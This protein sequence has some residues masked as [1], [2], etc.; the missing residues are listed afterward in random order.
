MSDQRAASR[1][2][3]IALALVLAGCGSAPSAS[4]VG[5]LTASPTSSDAVPSA[6]ASPTAAPTQIPS[7]AHATGPTDVA[8]RFEDRSGSSEFGGVFAPGPIFTLYG[9]GTVIFRNDLAM[10]PPAEGSIIRARPFLI[11]HLDEDQVQSVLRFA[12][13]EG[14]L[15]SVRQA[16]D[17]GCAVYGG[18]LTGDPWALQ[19]TV[20][21]GGLDNCVVVQALDRTLALDPEVDPDAV[22]RSAFVALAD[23]LRN[24][25]LQVPTQAWMPDRYWGILIG[26]GWPKCDTAIAWPWPDIAPEDFL[27]PKELALP[28]WYWPGGTAEERRVMSADEAAQLGFSGIAGGVQICLVGPDGTYFF[29]LW[30]L[31]PADPNW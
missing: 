30:P 31:S 16:A 2:S 4:P 12:L 18:E 13:R 21:A 3:V 11:V 14:G 24:F 23:Y 5:A 15:G 25:D 19:F 6:T 1:L 17:Q 9:D 8:L 29:A 26:P 28:E 10:P 7:I 27:L 22:A 20:H